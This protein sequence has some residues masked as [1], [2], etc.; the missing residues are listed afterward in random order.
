MIYK[1]FNYNNILLLIEWDIFF[2]FFSKLVDF[3]L[4]ICYNMSVKKINKKKIKKEV[5]QNG[6]RS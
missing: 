2:I 5:N 4:I 3:F 6:T 1:L